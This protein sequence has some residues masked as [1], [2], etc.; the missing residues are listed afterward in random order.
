MSL[1]FSILSTFGLSSLYLNDER[2]HVT[3]Y[4]PAYVP[5]VRVPLVHVW[6]DIEHHCAEGHRPDK[7]LTL[8]SLS[9]SR[10]PVWPL[11]ILILGS[12]SN[13]IIL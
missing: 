13:V 7:L 11:S 2:R 12:D 4:T 1:D 5:L 6:G 8:I 9:H 3:S 10:Y